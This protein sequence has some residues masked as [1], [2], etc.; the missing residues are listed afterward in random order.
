MTTVTTN[1]RN[2]VNNLIEICRDGMEGFET[3]A[4]AVNDGTLKNELEQ[5]GSQRGVF[6]AALSNAMEEM[7]FQPRTHGSIS[8]ALH[9][10]LISLMKIAPGDNEHAVLVACER[11][12]DAAL[13]AY[14]EASGTPLP[15]AI[16]ELVSTQYQI[17][18]ATHDR[19]RTLRDAS[20]HN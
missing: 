10:G 19:I 15:G 18:K 2:T 1:V 17:V 7:G 6:A 4:N 12:E 3:A 5:Y 8:G 20:D 13:E 11:G 9:R 14:M 16:A